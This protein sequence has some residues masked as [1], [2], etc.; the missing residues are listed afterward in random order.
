MVGSGLL[1]SSTQSCCVLAEAVRVGAHVV[2]LSSVPEGRG[3]LLVGAGHDAVA[4]ALALL[5]FL[6]AAGAR[7]SDLHG[8]GRGARG[9]P[10]PSPLGEGVGVLLDAQAGSHDLVTDGGEGGGGWLRGDLDPGI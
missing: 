8:H 1:R 6:L 5:I 7:V 4:L 2:L 3:Q 9:L 10:S